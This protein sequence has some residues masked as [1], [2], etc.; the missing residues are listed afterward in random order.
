[1]LITKKKKSLKSQ[2]KILTIFK[3]SIKNAE[4]ISKD[5]SHSSSSAKVPVLSAV[6]RQSYVCC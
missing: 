4:Q 5:T 6:T 3:D 2:Y 1:M